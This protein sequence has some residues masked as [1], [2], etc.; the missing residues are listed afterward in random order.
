MLQGMSY[1]ID[2][3]DTESLIRAATTSLS[4]KVVSQNASFLAPL[5]VNAVTRVCYSFTLFVVVQ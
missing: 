4:S 2:L 1:R 3:S 5:S